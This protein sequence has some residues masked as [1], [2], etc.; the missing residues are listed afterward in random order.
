MA[1][2]LLKTHQVT[3]FDFVGRPPVAAAESRKV[4]GS[5]TPLQ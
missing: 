5:A 1:S 4:Q 3:V 2:N